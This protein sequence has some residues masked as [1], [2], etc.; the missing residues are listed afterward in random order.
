MQNKKIKSIEEI[1][2]LSVK[3]NSNKPINIRTYIQSKLNDAAT[4]K[5][6]NIINIIDISKSY[7]KIVITLII[8]LI[9]GSAAY[10][11][12]KKF[13]RKRI[14]IETNKLKKLN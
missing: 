11:T 10:L 14:I 12:H 6:I 9:L 3:G 13:I 4:I 2:N 1:K 7:T 8:A 5:D